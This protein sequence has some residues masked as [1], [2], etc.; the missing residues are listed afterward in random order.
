MGQ[1]RESR[2][3]HLLLLIRQ[4]SE[5]LAYWK[6]A[7]D[8]GVDDHLPGERERSINYPLILGVSIRPLQWS[9]WRRR[10]SGCFPENVHEESGYLSMVQKEQIR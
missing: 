2:A 3:T 5:T 4:D 1:I 8:A 10:P 6:T 7:G 9:R